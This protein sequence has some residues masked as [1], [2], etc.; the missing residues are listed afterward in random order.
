[1]LAV[2]E[3]KYVVCLGNGESD[4]AFSLVRYKAKNIRNV[5]PSGTEAGKQG[6]VAFKRFEGTFTFENAPDLTATVIG[7]RTKPLGGAAGLH[8]FV[9]QK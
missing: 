8:G 1:M 7:V 3:P 5:I 4:S 6:C 2:V 9:Y